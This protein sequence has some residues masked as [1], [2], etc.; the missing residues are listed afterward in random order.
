MNYVFDD[1]GRAA[2]GY[3]GA[4]GDCVT[5]AVA[6]ATGEPYQAVYDALNSLSKLE[7][8]TRKSSARNGVQRPTFHKYLLARGWRW[9]PTMAIG[10]G[11]KVHL[12]PEEL[13]TGRLIVSVSRHLVALI[14]GVIHD[15]S[16]PSR[17]GNRCVYG[18]FEAPKCQA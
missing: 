15:T 6:I 5:R 3:K 11:C 18:Y 2:A 17:D 13:P 16:D 4:A 9:T 10:Q 14:D 1:G 12:R 8:R 7:R